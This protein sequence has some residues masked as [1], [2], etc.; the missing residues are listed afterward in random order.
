MKILWEKCEILIFRHLPCNSIGCV[1]KFLADGRYLMWGN[2]LAKSHVQHRKRMQF[3]RCHWFKKVVH[4]LFML[5]NDGDT[6][7]TS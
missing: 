1:A 2:Y 4:N 5:I 3:S 7:T 6:F